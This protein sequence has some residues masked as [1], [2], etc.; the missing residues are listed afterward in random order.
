M[1]RSEVCLELGL[2]IGSCFVLTVLVVTFLYYLC[3]L[4]A[5]FLFFCLWLVVALVVLIFILLRL[6]Y[7][8]F[9]CFD[10]LGLGGGIVWLV[11]WMPLRVLWVV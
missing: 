10:C 6:G 4:V 7:G 3:C 5:L 8:V 11:I 1:L 9:C 2:L